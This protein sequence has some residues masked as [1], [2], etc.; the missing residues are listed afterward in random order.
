MIYMSLSSFF[1][2]Q[3]HENMSKEFEM[4]NLVLLHYFLGIEVK[5]V[6]D[7][8]FI[9]QKKYAIDQLKSFH[10]SNYK[11]ASTPMNLNEKLQVEDGT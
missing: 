6:E 9:S 2:K 3:F 8:I 10:M 5:P 4:S 1:V 7:G 11:I